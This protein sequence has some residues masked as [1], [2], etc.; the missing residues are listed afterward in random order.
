MVRPSV[1]RARPPNSSTA[2]PKRRPTIRPTTMPMV[3]RRKVVSPIEAAMIQILAP[4]KARPPPT[5]AGRFPEH[6]AAHGGQQAEGDPVIDLLDQT[7]GDH[8]EPP[9]DQGR[10]GFDDTE[11]QTRLD[12][13]GQGRTGRRAA[14]DRRCES[15]GGHA[16]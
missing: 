5:E 9:A 8:A 6:P 12:P 7:R 14:S 2:L 16:E 3:A 13:A 11:H 4:M 10:D 1:T 15:I